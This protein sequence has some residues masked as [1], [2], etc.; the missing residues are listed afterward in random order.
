MSRSRLLPILL[1][2]S[3]LILFTSCGS[4]H[5]SKEKYYLIAT[6][7]GIPYWQNAAAGFHAAAEKMKVKGIV[8]GPAS[9]DPRA[10]SVAFLDAAQSGASGILISVSDARLMKDPIDQAIANGI[11]VITF[12]SDAPETSRLYFIGTNNY[13]AGFSGGKRLAEELKGKGNVIVF[14]MPDQP[15]LAE[16][17]RGYKDALANSPGIKITQ[18]VDIQGNPTVAFDT[19]TSVLAMKNDKVSGVICL[20]AQAGKEVAAVLNNHNVKDVTVIA[21]DTDADT[22]DWIQKGYI[23]AT[24]A[25]KPYTMAYTG[26]VALDSVYHNKPDTLAVNWSKRSFSPYPVFVDT[27]SGIVDKSNLEGFMQAQKQAVPSASR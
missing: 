4:G 9:F 21:F 1:V 22:L 19:M 7:T 27:G 15:N 26:L 8:A 2:L 13:E 23:S 3:T 11:P 17:L 6:N 20:E 25:Q 5:D 14:T 16:R 18:V 10:E 24:I 12:D